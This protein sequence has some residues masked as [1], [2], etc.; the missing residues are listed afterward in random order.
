MGHNAGAII[1][2]IDNPPAVLCISKLK[3]VETLFEALDPDLALI[4]HF[5]YQ[6]TPRLLSHRAPFVNLHCAR[7]PYIRGPDPFYRIVLRPDLYPPSEHAVTWHYMSKEL[8]QG[9]IILTK[10]A[11]LAV[12]QLD[13]LQTKEAGDEAFLNSADEALQLVEDG[14]QGIDQSELL[15]DESKISAEAL[16]Y[17]GYP[18][19]EQRTITSD[20]SLEEVQSLCRAVH[21]PFSALFRYDGQL[22]YVLRVTPVTREEFGSLATRLQDVGSGNGGTVD[23]AQKRIGSNVLQTFRDGILSMAIRKV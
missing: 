3:Q 20:M 8:D 2:E 10:S 16:E 23:G 21:H 18:N 12:N 7:L 1:D 13:W 9:R 6:I 14:F 11:P 15:K 4:W 22:Y 5:S 17:T 19:D